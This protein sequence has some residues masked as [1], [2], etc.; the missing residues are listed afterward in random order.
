MSR[1]LP[2]LLELPRRALARRDLVPALLRRASGV[3][4]ADLPRAV[5]AF[6]LKNDELSFARAL[7][8]RRSQL[9]LFRS[10]QRAF[11]G[12]FVVIDVS[13][14]AVERRRAVVLD[15]KHGARLRVGGGGAGIQLRNAELAVRDLARTTSVLAEEAPF[16]MV[17]GDSGAVLGF[18][19]AA[20]SSSDG[21]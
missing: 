3:A 5:E 19:R 21:A 6:A 10:N 17:T 11:C 9:R 2:F 13:S 20:Q 4:R 8:V 1:T 18:F 12:D 16:D 7:L 15:L 14:P